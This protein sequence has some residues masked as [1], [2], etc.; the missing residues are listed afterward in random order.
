[1]APMHAIPLRII[2]REIVTPVWL[3]TALDNWSELA[4][5]KCY[6]SLSACMQRRGGNIS[7]YDGIR[8]KFQIAAF[9]HC[10]FIVFSLF[11][12]CFFL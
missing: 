1:M 11:F 9:E 3:S 8:G 6:L 7:L 4:S 12:H 10:F 2:S 5:P